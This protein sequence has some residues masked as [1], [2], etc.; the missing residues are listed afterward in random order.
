MSGNINGSMDLGG[1][2]LKNLEGAVKKIPVGVRAYAETAARV[3]ENDAR[4]RAPWTDRTG[5]ARQ[6]LTAYVTEIQPAVCEITV[7]H[8]VPYGIYLELAH[9]K[10]FATIMPAIQRNSTAILKGLKILIEG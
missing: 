8:G 3:L 7:A 10:R 5:H 1:D 4:T 9:E 2:L 6:R